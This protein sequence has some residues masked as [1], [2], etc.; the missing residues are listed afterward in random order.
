MDAAYEISFNNDL[1]HQN[2]NNLSPRKTV[3]KIL[4]PLSDTQFNKLILDNSRLGNGYNPSNNNN[5]HS[6]LPQKTFLN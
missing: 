2:I 4:H 5:Y 6:N 1:K 3:T